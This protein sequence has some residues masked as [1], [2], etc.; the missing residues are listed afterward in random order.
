MKL[1]YNLPLGL[2]LAV[3]LGLAGCGDREEAEVSLDP[4]AFHSE[5]ECHVCGMVVM[6]FPGPKGQAVA[7]DGVRKFCS[8]AEMLSWWLQPENRI[9]QLRLYVHDMGRS[10]WD[11]PDDAY[12]VDATQ[13][14]YVTGTGLEGAMGASLASFAER[15]AADALAARHQGARVVAFSDIDEQFLQQAAAAQH[16]GMGHDMHS[17]PMDPHSH[18]GH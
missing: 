14:W 3:L 7:R 18:T 9:L 1:R 5:D 8:T 13:A 16:G 2:I 10:H 11:Q 6:D 17:Q 4:V 12:L 15:E